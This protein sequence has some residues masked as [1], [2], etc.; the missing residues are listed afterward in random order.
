MQLTDVTSSLTA[1]T[2]ALAELASQVATLQRSFDEAR[3]DADSKQTAV[4]QLEQAK[5]TAE[6]ELAVAKEALAK[7]EAETQESSVALQ[8]VKDEVGWAFPTSN[9]ANRLY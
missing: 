2:E 8:A 9:F 4:D 3:A 1:K 5:S 7:L 6:S